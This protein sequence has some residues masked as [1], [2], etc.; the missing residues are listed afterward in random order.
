MF[1]P[2]NTASSWSKG[3]LV[4][5]TLVNGKAVSG[6]DLCMVVW[7]SL[8]IEGATSLTLLELSSPVKLQFSYRVLFGREN[9][10]VRMHTMW[11]FF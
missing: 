10:Y 6:A 4:T 5:L 8:P 11:G 2:K 1:P 7:S 9:C 3:K